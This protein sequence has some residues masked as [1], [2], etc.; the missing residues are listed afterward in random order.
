MEKILQ[1]A[2]LIKL[3]IFDVD[4]VL[5]DGKLIYGHNGHEYKAFHVQDGL[6]MKLLQSSGVAVAI[7]TAKTSGIVTE[8]MKDLKIEHVYQGYEDK[9]PAYE[10]LKNKLQLTDT[11]IAYVGDD[12]PDLSVMRRVGLSITVANAPQLIQQSADWVTKKK[13]GKGAV[14]EICE[15]IL[16]AQ[17]NLEAALQPYLNR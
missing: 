15:F 13:G 16:Q 10:T 17:G 12:L 1:K 3:A 7:I 14:R 11:E 9:L 6:G 8:R 5:T 4:G 2:K